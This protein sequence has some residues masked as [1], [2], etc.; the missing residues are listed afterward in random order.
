MFIG[1]FKFNAVSDVWVKNTAYPV[2]LY[3]AAPGNDLE[4]VVD[5]DGNHKQVYA[6]NIVSTLGYKSDAD[7]Y[8]MITEMNGTY[9]VVSAEC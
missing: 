7:R 2:Y 5:E 3:K 4:A 8:C 6:M 9:W 1:S